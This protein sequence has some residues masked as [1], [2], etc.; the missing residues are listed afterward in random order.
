MSS[1]ISLT[2]FYSI[3]DNKTDKRLD[4][5]GWEHFEKFLYALS[6]RKLPNKKSA[7]LISPAIYEPGTTRLNKTTTEWAGWAAVDVDDIEIKGELSDFVRKLIPKWR[8]VC[9][10][11]ASSTIDR[12]KFRLVIELEEHI[13]AERIRHFWF[14]LQ[15]YL[16]S[17]GDK[18][19]KDLSRMYY[20]PAKYDSAYNFIF[21]GDGNPLNVTGLLAAY[22]YVERQNSNN[23]L[24]RLPEDIQKSVIAHRQNQMS[25]QFTWT[26]YR[27]CPFWP[28]KLAAE[29]TLLS[30]AGWYAKMYSILCAVVVNAIHKEYPITATQIADLAREFD[31]DHGGWYENR[32]LDLEADRA[33]EWAYRNT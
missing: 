9:Y 6:E 30:D 19:C 7:E 17:T 8:F 13:P 11:T 1:K 27:D 18:Q 24:D 31:A 28:K 22:P 23:F 32:P 21:S 25:G 33:I 26:S 29:Y 12:P 16:D 4:F 3:K 10:S 20:T 15:S 5:S 2:S 14:A